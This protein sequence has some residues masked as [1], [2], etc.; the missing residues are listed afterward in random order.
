MAQP[1]STLAPQNL[2][3]MEKTL[4]PAAANSNQ[5]QPI[6][7]ADNM[8]PIVALRSMV[9]R[10]E[11]KVPPFRSALKAPTQTAERVRKE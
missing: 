3:E 6:Q 1:T 10:L 9:D 8:P 4:L 11:Y 2:N 5:Q 7:G